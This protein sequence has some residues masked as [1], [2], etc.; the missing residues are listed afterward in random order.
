VSPCMPGHQIAADAPGQ[1]RRDCHNGAGTLARGQDAG[2]WRE[3]AALRGG[4]REWVIIWLAPAGEFR[5]YRRLPGTRRDAAVS[6]ATAEGLAAAMSQAECTAT[7]RRQDG[8]Q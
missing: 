1:Q 3:V 4:H 7:G 6:A 8:R 5:A 2:R